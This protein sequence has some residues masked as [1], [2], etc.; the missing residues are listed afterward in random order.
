MAIGGGSSRSDS[1]CKAEYQCAISPLRL[2]AAFELSL[3]SLT[4]SV[5][6][7]STASY[8]SAPLTAEVEAISNGE[9]DETVEQ[10][11]A[12]LT[13]RRR[14]VVPDP[15][16][17]SSQPATSDSAANEQPAVDSSATNEQPDAH[18]SSASWLFVPA[19]SFGGGCDRL[20]VSQ[21][22]YEFQYI[23]YNA[24]GNCY[25]EPGTCCSLNQLPFWHSQGAE[26]D[27]RSLPSG[28]FLDTTD[29]RLV[30]TSPNDW[31]NDTASLH[32]NYSA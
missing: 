26:A 15:Y 24:T 5:L 31:R 19:A 30:H 32:L 7:A 21:E 25:L 3:T 18:S 14:L 6:A 11:F 17:A 23:H 22:D 4:P 20:G 2:H 12:D 27:T 28:G 29:S 13:S 1:V 9:N 10:K 8:R 16:I